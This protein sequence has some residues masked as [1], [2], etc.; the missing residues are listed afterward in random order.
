MI[1][2]FQCEN[3]VYWFWYQTKSHCF[4]V[5]V[6]REYLCAYLY[7]DWQNFLI[8]LKPN[9]CL[10]PLRLHEVWG[11]YFSLLIFPTHLL[12][13]EIYNIYIQ[14]NISM[15]DGLKSK[16]QGYSSINFKV[17]L[18]VKVRLNWEWFICWKDTEKYQRSWFK[19][20]LSKI[21][22]NDWPD[23]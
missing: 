10:V 8:Y 12:T 6:Y 4:C 7:R 20:Q 3:T 13:F 22:D 9:L 11:V 21:T 23:D 18:I 16:G 17:V 15:F 2:E 1:K 14:E 19:F 5:P